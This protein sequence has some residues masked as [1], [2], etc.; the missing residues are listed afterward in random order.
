[1][2]S[3]TQSVAS[4]F[5]NILGETTG[6]II[7][8]HIGNAT[9]GL[10]PNSSPSQP[11][12]VR[13]FA[14]AVETPNIAVSS[15][16]TLLKKQAIL[17]S[18][19]DGSGQ[20]ISKSTSYYASAAYRAKSVDYTSS[21]PLS[22][23]PQK[24][25][26]S[27][28]PSSSSQKRVVAFKSHLNHPH[29]SNETVDL[30]W[31]LNNK[32]SADSS[33]V[34]HVA[35]LDPWKDSDFSWS[36]EAQ[37]LKN[38]F[39]KSLCQTQHNDPQ[40]LKSNSSLPSVLTLD[41]IHKH[42][43][44]LRLHGQGI[45]HIDAG[46]SKFVHL[47]ELSLTGNLISVVEHIPTSMVM[48]HLNA[49]KLNHIPELAH[50]DHLLH[51]GLGYNQIDTLCNLRHNDSVRTV[52]PHQMK[53][54]SRPTVSKSLSQQSRTK[55]TP[56]A[57]LLPAGHFI[58][59][60][61]SSAILGSVPKDGL[62]EGLP[63]TLVSLD[64]A[65][66]H[67]C[68]L[69]ETVACL[70]KLPNLKILFLQGN[71]LCMAN[72]YPIYV[73]RSLPRLVSLDEMLTIDLVR[74]NTQSISPAS[75]DDM[76]TVKLRIVATSLTGVSEAVGIENETP[77]QPPDDYEYFLEFLLGICCLAPVL[78]HPVPW[79]PMVLETRFDQ[80]VEFGLCTMIRNAFRDG[81]CVRLFRR[82]LTYTASSALDNAV[83]SRVV[84]A[85][86][87]RR[88]ISSGGTQQM[89]SDQP[90]LMGSAVSPKKA[91]ERLVKGGAAAGRCQGQARRKEDTGMQ[92]VATE[93]ETVMI[94][95]CNL[96]LLDLV[97]GQTSLIGDYPFEYIST[98]G[99]DTNAQPTMEGTLH[100]EIWLNPK[101]EVDS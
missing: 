56:T 20:I 54:S 65:W 61:L 25:I 86:S 72:P 76:K 71:P 74:L 12:E 73:I 18:S 67:L 13:V 101:M 39:L 87:A 3:S 99:S 89:A 35:Q 23:P 4:A 58:N 62:S 46:L 6:V 11:R 44:T 83:P 94:G 19:T 59:P 1:M 49:N 79:T 34:S 48:L 53:K 30:S 51:L 70:K 84:R 45:T 95:K 69:E 92:W 38:L 52:K 80:I 40:K 5:R 14:A 60:A 90:K 77:N 91:A 55:A 88:G 8:G 41:F 21:N 37:S 29:Q 22:L 47:K 16:K 26:H 10:P 100:A 66:N 82:R 98:V 24:H 63:S 78:S 28:S 31:I 81:I 50:L 36:D 9:V 85:E 96:P 33:E 43:E 57:H 93:A 68:D 75:M 32:K 97:N 7:P 15:S 64:L 2:T 42:F 17:A 27:I